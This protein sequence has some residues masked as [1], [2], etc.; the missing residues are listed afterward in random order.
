M[1]LSSDHIGEWTYNIPVMMPA[2]LAALTA[3]L[4]SL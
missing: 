4:N 1:D 2:T 3:Y